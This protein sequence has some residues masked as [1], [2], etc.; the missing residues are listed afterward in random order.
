MF[1][2]WNKVAALALAFGFG[3][4]GCSG[5]H[6]LMPAGP[7]ASGNN[8]RARIAQ[9]GRI[10]LRGAVPL[11][12]QPPEGLQMAF[13]MTDG[14]VLAQSYAGNTWYRYAPDASGNYSNG[15]WT[16][17]ATLPTG[18]APSAFSSAVLADGR[19]LISGGEYNTPGNYDLQLVNLGAVYDPVKNTWKSLGHPVGWKWIG[20]SPASI[21]PDG[22]FLIG[23][24]LT[25]QVAALTPSTLH[26][27]KLTYKGKAD[28]NAEEGWT[29]LADGTIL[30]ADVKKA[31]HA[32]IYNAATGT[33]KSAG[34]TIVDL[35][36][37]SPYHQCLPYGPAPQDCYLPPGEIGPL[38]LRPDGTVF[39]TG[40]YSSGYG[41]GH[42][43]IFHSLGS[44]AGTWTVGPDFPNGDNAGDSFSVL[45]PSG[46][47]L[48]FGVSGTLYEFDGT[49]FAQTG[50]GC[51]APLLLPTGQVMIINYSTVSLYTPS[52][53]P[54]SSWLPTISSVQKTL[55]R[56]QTYTIT[57]TQFNGL[58]QAMSF[59]D[60][61]QNA[62]NYPLVRITNT[63]SG[64][65]FYART[66][67]HSSMGV[68]TGTASVNTHFD[69][70][71][72]M[73]TGASTLQV[74]AN[75]IASK[76]VNVTVK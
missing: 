26:F 71:S 61:F 2:S 21:L 44:Q 4:A 73:E 25:K 43:S 72:T 55:T 64:H 39:A 52:G 30:T 7:A 24:K 58:S 17:A 28:F 41:V 35:H 76:T 67:D 13:L 56:G 45:L 10:P 40:S 49:K 12:S 31:P 74:V 62:T 19:L 46:N 37:P 51:C 16:Q 57:G 20:D 54:Q 3:A 75:G 33:W 11:A 32:E 70:P 1:R 60:E 34:S 53:Q 38:M 23:Q 47:V 63:S 6:S 15:T 8:L 48:V 29:L 22:R 59:G 5:S 18:Y 66:H 9:G 65:V 14:T 50:S 69:V 68:A 36:S 27:T 42:T